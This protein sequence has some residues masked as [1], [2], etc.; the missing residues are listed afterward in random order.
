MSKNNNT[1]TI[2]F[3]ARSVED[4]TSVGGHNYA[5]HPTTEVLCLAYKVGEEPENLWLPEYEGIPEW[6]R[7]RLWEHGWFVEAHNAF[8]EQCIWYYIMHKQFGW[9]QIPLESWACSAALASTHA[10]PRAL[11]KAGAALHTNVVKDQEGKGTMLQVCRPR[12][13]LEPFW[14]K[15]DKLF[16]RIANEMKGGLRQKYSDLKISKKHFGLEKEDLLQRMIDTRQDLFSDDTIYIW[17]DDKERMDTLYSYC[18]DDVLAEE[19][20]AK[21]LPP[22]SDRERQVWLLDQKINHRGIYCDLSTVYDAIE[23][24]KGYEEKLKAEVPQLSGG[25][26]NSVNQVD[27]LTKY[28][29]RYIPHLDSLSADTLRNMLKKKE[30]L[31]QHVVRLMEIR[32]ALSK[33]STK[34]L[35]AMDNFASPEDGRVRDLLLY[36]G[37]ST[38][39]WSGRGIQV[40]NLPKST[41]DRDPEEL[42]ADIK[43]KN[44]PYLEQK[45]GNPL[46]VVSSSIRSMLTAAPNNDL[47]LADFAAIEART[48][49]WLAGQEDALNMFWGGEDIYKDMAAHIYN[50]TADKI[51]KPSK[52]RDLGK[53]AVLG[54]FAEDTLVLTDRGWVGIIDVRESDMLWDGIE[55]VSHKGL[56]YKGIKD[57]I[58]QK[59][60]TV[61]PDHLILTGDGWR[62][63]ED[64]LTKSFLFQSAKKLVDL[65]YGVG[66]GDTTGGVNPLVMILSF[67]VN[68]AQKLP[69]WLNGLIYHGGLQPNAI[70]VL[71]N[72]RSKLG[73]CIGNI[74]ILFPKMKTD[75]GCL[76]GSPLVYKD[77]T[78]LNVLP[79]NTTGG[80][81]LKF[82]NLGEK[83]G[84]SSLNTLSPWRGGMYRT[85]NWIA[86]TWTKAISQGT[87]DSV[88]NPKTHTIKGLLQ[89]CRTKSSNLKKKTHVYDLCSAGP[90]SRFLVWSSEGP[91]IAHNSGYQMGWKK[92]II[93]CE[94]YGIDVD[95]EL[96]KKAIYG[97]RDRFD[98]V[99]QL[100][101]DQEEAAKR[102]TITKEPVECGKTTWFVENGFLYCRL[103]SGRCLAYSEPRVEWVEDKFNPGRKKQSL[104]HMG[105]DINKKW[106]RQYTYGGLLVENIT[107]GTARDVMVENMLTLEEKGY[108]ILFTV[109]DE[110]IVEV[111]EGFGSVE[112]FEQLLQRTPDWAVGLPILAEGERSKR[113]KN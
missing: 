69:T 55:W 113:Y 78:T 111:P 74:R 41:L 104:S 44:V 97:Y 112:E 12:I 43:T 24:V 37:A 13:V 91:I 88:Q 27:K 72:L 23:V 31:P 1:I 9:P 33:T 10:L 8:F 73:K 57:T 82:T 3:E 20:I 63:A 103:P 28:L 45:Y 94:G 18:L 60:L 26:V 42:V 68:A 54:C 38:G 76:I 101:K 53:Q 6:V 90:R 77:V 51:E 75:V 96:A 109:H 5:A 70:V 79:T 32:L 2:D 99:P 106:V 47:I 21:A 16:T 4:L 7:D 40:Q 65:P 30:K 81:A 25:E 84:R 48:V 105:L 89:K 49:F 17:W 107:Q 80:G 50:T 14:F 56:K 22:L 93:T 64:A 92:F 67:L 59:G 66:I 85:W 86:S 98:K 39:R 11:D 58:C 52:N 35:Y 46:E 62:R 83:I 34:K 87:F 110:V 15:D 95:E 19:A 71:K 61:T 100:W 36:H 108:K 102:A 29:Q